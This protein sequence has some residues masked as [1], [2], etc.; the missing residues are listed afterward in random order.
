[1]TSPVA[2][3]ASAPG[4][5]AS[6]ACFVSAACMSASCA[7]SGVCS[8]SRARRC[9]GRTS[10]RAPCRCTSASRLELRVEWSAFSVENAA[11]M[12]LFAV[13]IC[14]ENARLDRLRLRVQVHVICGSPTRSRRRSTGAPA[15]SRPSSSPTRLQLPVELLPRLL[16]VVELDAQPVLS[17]AALRRGRLVLRLLQRV[18]ERLGQQV[19]AGRH[20]RLR[21]EV[22]RERGGVPHGDAG[23]L[24]PFVSITWPT[25]PGTVES[26]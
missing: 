16:E 15:G 25:S 8:P 11:W 13:E 5:C 9:P 22:L 1:V 24:P 17:D 26:P 3:A 10:G 18:P 2:R 4:Q 12:L 21:A 23:T 14:D 7:S 19:R 6:V 20:R